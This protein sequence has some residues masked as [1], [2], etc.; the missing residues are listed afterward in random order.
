MQKLEQKLDKLYEKAAKY[1]GSTP[2]QLLF[3]LSFLIYNFIAG[4]EYINIIS[5]VAIS[6]ALLL[7]RGQTVQSARMEKNIKQSEKDTKKDLAKSEEV[8]KKLQ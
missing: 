2:S 8:L 4:W 7:L 5:E 3:F 6:L 1:F